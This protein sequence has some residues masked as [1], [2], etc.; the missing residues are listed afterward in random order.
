[1]YQG[2]MRWL[3]FCLAA[4]APTAAAAPLLGGREGPCD[5]YEKA[6]TPCVAA[7]SVTRAL[8]GGYGGALYQVKRVPDDGTVLDVGVNKAGFARS[9]LQ[10]AYCRGVGCV[11]HR[12][13]DQSP[14]ANHL[15][16]AP[17][18]GAGGAAHHP[19]TPVWATTER[20]MLSGNPVYGAFFE[21]GT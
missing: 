20:L 18:G 19:D 13:L 21:G 6:K 16:T 14:H 4:L 1:M 15:D 12:I 2:R 8:Y 11:I 17:G 9:D 7:H 3:L 5:I 10:D